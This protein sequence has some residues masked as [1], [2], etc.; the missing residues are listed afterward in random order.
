MGSIIQLRSI[1]TLQLLCSTRGLGKLMGDI[2]DYEL[3]QMGDPDNWPEHQPGDE[4][5]IPYVYT[6]DQYYNLH[7]KVVAILAQSGLSEWEGKRLNYLLRAIERDK[8]NLKMGD[9]NERGSLRR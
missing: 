7:E 9:T 3:Y 2:L 6:L 4:G 5:Y 1:V 8:R